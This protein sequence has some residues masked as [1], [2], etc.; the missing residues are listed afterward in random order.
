M[1]VGRTGHV[2]SFPQGESAVSLSVLRVTYLW[3]GMGQEHFKSTKV[4][5]TAWRVWNQTHCL[6]LDPL[7]AV[8]SNHMT[9]HVISHQTKTKSMTRMV[10]PPRRGQVVVTPRR[11][12]LLVVGIL[13]FTRKM[14]P[15]NPT[16]PVMKGVGSS[17][18]YIR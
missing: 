4:I 15:P 1:T 14:R 3:W 7:H 9:L 18:W 6:N 10:P 17:F 2:K 16:C 5:K 13:R 12:H 8:P 11:R